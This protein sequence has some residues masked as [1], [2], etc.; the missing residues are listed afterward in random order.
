MDKKKNTSPRF[1]QILDTQSHIFCLVKILSA[2][3]VVTAIADYNG[4]DS[5]KI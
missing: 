1:I 5:K 2:K 4:K 3:H